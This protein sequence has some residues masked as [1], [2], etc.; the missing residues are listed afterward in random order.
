MFRLLLTT[1]ISG[2]MIFLASWTYGSTLSRSI[3]TDSAFPSPPLLSSFATASSLLPLPSLPL[4]ELPAFSLPLLRAPWIAP[5]Y[6]YWYHCLTHYCHHCLI[7]RYCLQC[8]FLIQDEVPPLL[9]WVAESVLAYIWPDRHG[10]E[11][12]AATTRRSMRTSSLVT[13]LGLF[14]F[15][16][17]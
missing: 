1:F 7:Q 9:H 12:R 6:H 14:P 4:P 11:L 13:R 3:T 17:Y 5:D 16:D 15:V 8:L 2:K 10:V